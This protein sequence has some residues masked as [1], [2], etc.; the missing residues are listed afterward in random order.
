[1]VK[2]LKQIGQSRTSESKVTEIEPLSL[3]ASFIGASLCS[4]ELDPLFLFAIKERMMSR[5][6]VSSSSLPLFS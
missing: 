5:N 2:G 4:F 6:E 1:M 3:L